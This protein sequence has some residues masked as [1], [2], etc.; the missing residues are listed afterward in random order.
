MAIGGLLLG[1]VKDEA[2]GVAH[3]GADAA[4]TMAEIDAIIPARAAHRS[5]MN[6]KD[7]SVS[8]R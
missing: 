6:S 7:D 2:K 4:D 1:V 5:I 8:L 3:S